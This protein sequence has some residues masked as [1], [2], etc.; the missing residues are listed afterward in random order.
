MSNASHKVVKRVRFTPIAIGAAALA[1]VLLSLTMTGTLAGFTAS[2]TNNTNTA[3]SGSLVMQEQNSGGTVTCLSTDG[4]TVST[5][6]ATCSTINKFGG[7]TTMV[8]GQ[9]TNTTVTIKNVGTVTPSTFTLTPGA[10]CTQ[11]NSG[12][13][14][15]SAT[16]LC[17]KLNLVITNTTTT[18]VLYSGTLAALANAAAITITTPPGPAVTDTFTFAL[19]LNSSAGNTYQGL[20]AS[21]P[22]TWAFA[23]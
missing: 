4:G 19:T 5:N 7:S 23:S 8:P 17:A 10:A 2:I 3:A 6:T 22:L 16:D 15:G 18:Q 20:Q 14:N 12:T 21:L 11:S 9:T 1:A 13:Q